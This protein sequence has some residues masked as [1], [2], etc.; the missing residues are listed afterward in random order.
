MTTDLEALRA[1]DLPTPRLA[2]LSRLLLAASTPAERHRIIDDARREAL[3]NAWKS[4]RAVERA[5]AEQR[6]REAVRGSQGGSRRSPTKVTPEIV[7]SVQRLR[8]EGHSLKAIGEQLGI[9][10]STVHRILDREPEEKP[11]IP[12]KKRKKYVPE[13]LAPDDQRH[14]SNAGYNRGCR[15]EPCVEARKAYRA[16][17]KANPVGRVEKADHGTIAKYTHGCRCQPCRDAIAE[18]NRR[19]RERGTERAPDRGV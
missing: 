3:R 9:S 19:R 16:E 17:R 10:E 14:G 5:F 13:P 18:Y 1:L 15:C 4:R 7:A 2:Y 12:A 8:G 11:V 6:Q